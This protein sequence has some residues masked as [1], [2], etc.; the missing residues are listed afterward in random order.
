MYG[1]GLA[2][3]GADWIEQFVN[4]QAGDE[5]L[6]RQTREQLLDDKVMDFLKTKVKLNEAP[7]ALDDFKKMV[8]TVN[9]SVEDSE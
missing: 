3:I 1:Y 4:K 9:A 6:V 7:V 5:K 8:E 2:N